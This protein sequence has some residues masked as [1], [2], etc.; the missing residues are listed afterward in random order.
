MGNNS[1]YYSV[2]RAALP[3]IEREDRGQENESN[4]AHS[5]RNRH[6]TGS[7][8]AASLNSIY[9][10]PVSTSTVKWKL[11]YPGFTA[12]VERKSHIWH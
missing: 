5:V 6:L 8:L 9:K 1:V 12:E 2:H 10:T 3:R 11:N 4:R 7:K